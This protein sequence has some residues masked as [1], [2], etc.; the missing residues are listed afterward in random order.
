MESKINKYLNK[1]GYTVSSGDYSGYKVKFDFK[2]SKGGS[3]YVSS[4][5]ADNDKFQGQ[6]IGNTLQLGNQFTNPSFAKRNET[7][8]ENGT[9]T[10][11]NTG[12]QTGDYKNIVMNVLDDNTMNRI[13]EIFHTLGAPK[14]MDN[15]P[16]GI[17][18]Y[19]PER[20]IQSD[21]DYIINNSFLP[22][23]IKD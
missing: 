15:A 11:E 12:G 21:I 6:P 5:S 2:F 18:S 20:P 19:P 8:Q 4:Q 14:S 16:K 13:H 10:F 3:E 1:Q 7:E 17:L 22:K 23:I 9:V